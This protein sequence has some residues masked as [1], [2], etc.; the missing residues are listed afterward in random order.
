M[1]PDD[2][3]PLSE[4]SPVRKNGG[5]YA[6]IAV[7]VG[8]A[9]LAIVLLIANNAQPN[10][11]AN[12]SLNVVVIFGVLAIAAE[13]VAIV[14]WNV[15]LNV[16]REARVR[17]KAP[18]VTMAGQWAADPWSLAPL[19]WWDGSRWTEHTSDYISS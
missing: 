6:L 15:W 18:V 9:S 1:G 10:D 13:V 3:P 19:R 5:V 17:A 16:R 14:F 2:V 4:L 12:S 11:N 7:G 8:A